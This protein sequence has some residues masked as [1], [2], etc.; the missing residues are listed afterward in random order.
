M[1]I[2]YRAEMHCNKCGNWF[3]SK[4]SSVKP[5][6]LATPI[7]KRAKNMGWARYSK[8]ALLDICPSCQ[9]ANK[10]EPK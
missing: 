3:A 4:Q 7:L 1:T 6:G 2:F 8:L 10:V 9:E 5:T